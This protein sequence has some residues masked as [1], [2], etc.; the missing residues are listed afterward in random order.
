M[1]LEWTFVR[2]VFQPETDAFGTECIFTGLTS[3]AFSQDIG[4]DRTTDVIINERTIDTISGKG[5]GT[6]DR[7]FLCHR[8]SLE[9][10]SI[11]YVD[12]KIQR[13]FHVV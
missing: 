1:A 10:T 4:T 7:L 12:D 11:L 6:H 3:D 9:C 8:R 5:I 2:V 13:L